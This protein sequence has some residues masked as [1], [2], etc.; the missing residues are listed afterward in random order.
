MIESDTY[1]AQLNDNDADDVLIAKTIYTLDDYNAMGGMENYGGPPTPPTGHLTSYNTTYTL[2]GNVTGRTV[3]S[4]V[5][6]G[7]S[8]TWLSKIDIFG[9]IVKEQ[10]SLL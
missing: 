4:D 10:L 9:T 2:R 3:F 5:G 7:T 6:A 1:D 8:I